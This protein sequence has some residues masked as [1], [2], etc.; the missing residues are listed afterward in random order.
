MTHSRVSYMYKYDLG[1][2]C[3][4]LGMEQLRCERMPEIHSVLEIPK[5]DELHRVL[6]RELVRHGDRTKIGFAF[7]KPQDGYIANG[8]W[9]LIVRG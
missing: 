2:P 4:L 3:K 5:I 8:Y 7:R 6:E 1:E 9:S